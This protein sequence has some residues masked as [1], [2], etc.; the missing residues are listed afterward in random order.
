MFN[1]SP[2]GTQVRNVQS[3]SGLL[4]QSGGKASRAPSG[5]GLSALSAGGGLR[6]EPSESSHFM[7][8]TGCGAPICNLMNLTCSPLSRWSHSTLRLELSGQGVH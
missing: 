2:Y 7:L 8:K 3:Q 1:E 5:C 6:D 4:R